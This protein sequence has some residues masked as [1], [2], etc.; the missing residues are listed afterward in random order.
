MKI[1][2]QSIMTTLI[3]R[4]TVICVLLCT[5]VFCW[6]QSLSIV[7]TKKHDYNY[8]HN[9]ESEFGHR[10]PPRPITCIIDFTSSEISFS[11]DIED[12]E[13]YEL[14]DVSQ[15]LL[16]YTGTDSS[17]LVNTIR[18]LNQECMLIVITNS[19]SYTGYINH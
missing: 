5:S 15:S 2:N 13:Y 6:G 18:G 16:L 3:Q 10:V 19:M 12:I 11:P 4:L 14:W 8:N 1:S 9:D 7:L 17:T